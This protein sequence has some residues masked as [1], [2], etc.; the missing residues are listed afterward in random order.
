MQG[1]KRKK[2]SVFLAALFCTILFE[3]WLCRRG[4]EAGPAALVSLE[5]SLLGFEGM[6]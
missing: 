2:Y 5:I 6:T 3:M 1:E 4:V